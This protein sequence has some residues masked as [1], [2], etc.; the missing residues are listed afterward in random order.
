MSPPRV[1]AGLV[2]VIPASSRAP[3]GCP[4][5]RP[6]R[7]PPT[8]PRLSAAAP[9]SHRCTAEGWPMP[10]VL[11]DRRG[12]APVGG[13]DHD[14]PSDLGRRQAERMWACQTHRVDTRSARRP[15]LRPRRRPARP[16]RPEQGCGTGARRERVTG[17]EPA[18]PAWKAGALPL[19]YTREVLPGHSTGSPGRPRLPPPRGVA[20]LGSAP[21]LGAGGRRFKS[22]HPDTTSA[23][24]WNTRG[25]PGAVCPCRQAA[26]TTT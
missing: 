21:A 25:H 6:V 19:S 1:E 4:G 8:P 7:S 15:S 26:P 14:R 13:G 3:P 18:W 16:G 20:Q 9:S 22:C 10:M 24:L 12:Q 23:G 2:P 11:L 5:H 17:I